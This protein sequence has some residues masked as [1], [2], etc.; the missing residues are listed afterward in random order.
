MPPGIQPG[1]LQSGPAPAVVDTAMAILEFPPSKPAPATI[2]TVQDT[3]LFGD[4][5]Y[6]ILD[7]AG[8]QEGQA[9]GFPEARLFVENDWLVPVPVEKRVLLDR[10]LGRKAKSAPEMSDL[11]DLG[12]QTRLVQSFRVY[13]TNPFRL[14]VGTFVSPVIQVRARVGGTEEM[15]GI[16]E[17]RPV[18]WSPLA[19]LGLLLSL[20]LVL[21]LSWL[22]WDRRR[23]G[24]DL[25][26]RDLPP[27]AWLAAAIELR[28][29]LHEG[30]LGRGDSRVF[31]DGLAG[32]SRRFV[33]GRYRIAAQEMTGREII[34]ACS[35]LGHRSTQT[36]IFARMIDSVDHSRYNPEAAGAGWCRDQA[37]LLYD[38]MAAVRILPRYSEVSADLRSQG[39]KAWSDLKRELVSGPG[40]LRGSTVVS[41]GR[42]T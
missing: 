27:P 40:R 42:E 37:V 18:G 3:V 1:M 23:R 32:I 33:A 25:S 41:S 5:F 13:R 24:D 11:P 35:D 17:P 15:I 16:R 38:Q 21:W 12:D 28:D 6:L 9:E 26:D 22:L 10:L 4:V 36:G 29:L 7:F 14:Q 2:S 8:Q 39:D 20:L 30:S 34:E 19:A 31:L